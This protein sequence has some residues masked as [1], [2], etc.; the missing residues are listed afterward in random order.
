MKDEKRAHILRD[1]RQAARKAGKELELVRQGRRR[2]ARPIHVFT[3]ER[4]GRHWFIKARD[5]PRVFTQVRRLDHAAAAATDVTALMLDVDPESFDVELRLIGEHAAAREEFKRAQA[6][7]LLAEEQLLATRAGL[8]RDLAAQGLSVRDIG[9][10]LGL[11]Y[12]R[13][14]QLKG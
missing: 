13:V 7:A 5:L 14:A 3:V 11:S 4:D 9:A 8:I 10:I 2:A 1:I 6:Q 12:Q